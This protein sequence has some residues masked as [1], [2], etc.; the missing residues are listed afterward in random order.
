VEL[1]PWKLLE[2]ITPY[3][4]VWNSNGELV[5]L[6]AALRKL[7]QTEESL[8]VLQGKIELL[9]PFAGVIEAA[10]LPELT[11]LNL[12][13]SHTDKLDLVIRGQIISY[14]GFWILVGSPNVHSVAQLTKMGLNLSDLPI[15]DGTGDLLIAVETSL[16]AHRETQE[17]SKELAIANEELRSVNLALSEFVPPSVRKSMGLKENS[18]NSVGTQ[19]AVVGQ[20][21]ESLQQTLEFRER[22]L[23]NVS[24]ELRTPLNAI[25]GITEVLQ[26]GVYGDLT[27]KQ[28][29][30]LQTVSDS[31]DH[32]LS[33]INDVLD[34]SKIESGEATLRIRE[35]DL[36]SLCNSAMSLVLRQAAKKG[37]QISLNN[38]SQYEFIHVDKRR[39][40]QVL[41]N[42]LSNAVKFTD[43]GGI[44]IDID[45]LPAEKSICICVGDTGIGIAMEDQVRLFHPFVQVDHGRSRIYQG[46]GLGLAIAQCNVQLHGGR[47]ELESTPGKGSR[48][49]VILPVHATKTE[50][51]AL[52]N[53]TAN[54]QHAHEKEGI[55]SNL[56]QGKSGLLGSLRVLVVD[57]ILD[58]RRHLVD[59]LRHEGCLVDVAVDGIAGLQSVI[60]NTP[61][62][63]L[64]DISCRA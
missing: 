53:T 26:E 60:E 33:L 24:H 55:T 25:L 29:E 58:N 13:V 47:I 51:H 64:V 62:I 31:G 22:F 20:F 1:L 46:T 2:P 6:S 9:R 14:E 63:L 8:P 21:I 39:I 61:D 27:E 48:F 54:E 44:A 23:A 12:Q 43:Q 56:T 57:D 4:A 10:W 52:I 50:V 41:L 15:H 37:L 19:A 11:D 28:L 36:D 49:S 5:H 3:H 38:R 42:L 17:R 30:M 34:L 32:L 35:C 59:Y 16:V 40:H 7:W 18:Q 45:D